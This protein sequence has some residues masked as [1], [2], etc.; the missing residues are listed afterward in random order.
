[1]IID[2][3]EEHSSVYY[4]VAEFAPEVFEFPDDAA[5]ELA[6]LA[7]TELIRVHDAVILTKASDGSIDAAK[8]S[9]EDP[10]LCPT[11]VDVQLAEVMALE[12]VA[13]FAGQ[14]TPGTRAGVVVWENLWSL[15][16]ATAAHRGGAELVAVGRVAPAEAIDAPRIDATIG[17]S[18]AGVLPPR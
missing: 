18:S 12:E 10:S 7:G 9:P 15:P 17:N 2:P 14:M 3:D 8:V 6:V 16:F 5:F 11:S 1:M 13:R 4:L